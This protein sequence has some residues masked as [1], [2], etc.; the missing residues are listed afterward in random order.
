MLERQ[1]GRAPPTPGAVYLDPSNG[2]RVNPPDQPGPDP[3]TETAGGNKIKGLHESLHKEWDRIPPAWGPPPDAA[4]M[5][6][7]R[8]LLTEAGTAPVMSGEITEGVQAAAT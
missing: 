1:R 2:Q 6:E 4:I 3:K 7:V 5:A 8:R